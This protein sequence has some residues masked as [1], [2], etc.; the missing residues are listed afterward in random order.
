M[1]NIVLFKGETIEAVAGGFLVTNTTY[2]RTKYQM[3]A[4]LEV[5]G[6]REYL[7][8]THDRRDALQTIEAAAKR[9]P[10]GA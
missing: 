7:G 1:E 2:V 10:I 3:H 9:S 8:A 4:V 6:E 5:N